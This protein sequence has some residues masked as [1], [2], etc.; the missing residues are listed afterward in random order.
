[1]KSCVV[2]LLQI[3]VRNT[4]VNKP[5]LGV[6]VMTCVNSMEIVV[7]I[8]K[9]NVWLKPVKESVVNIIKV[10]RVS[11]TTP[12]RNMVTAVLIMTKCVCRERKGISF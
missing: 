1:M 3:H 6:G 12:V 10:G 2:A 5:Q 4:V 9:R 7:P 8:T 11:A